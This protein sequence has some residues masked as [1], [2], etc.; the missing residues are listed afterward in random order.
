MF[1]PN[2]DSMF[3]PLTQI[4]CEFIYLFLKVSSLLQT[5]EFEIAWS[6]KWDFFRYKDT[7]AC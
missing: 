6:A 2:Y 4:N 3:S 7:L 5:F 1:Q